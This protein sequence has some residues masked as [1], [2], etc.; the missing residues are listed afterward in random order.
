MG[1]NLTYVLPRAVIALLP[2][3]AT[4]WVLT[5]LSPQLAPSIVYI[6]GISWVLAGVV[7]FGY[8]YR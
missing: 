1:Q 8:L 7:C 2:W 6:T 4:Y 3:G 5:A